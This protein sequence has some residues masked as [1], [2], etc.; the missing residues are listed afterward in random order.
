M[1]ISKSRES[2]PC[3]IS[4]GGAFWWLVL[5]ARTRPCTS[6]KFGCSC[7]K[8]AFGPMPSPPSGEQHSTGANHILNSIPRLDSEARKH[9]FTS[10]VPA[11]LATN[12][13]NVLDVQT[14]EL[15]QSAF[16]P[17]VPA[18]PPAELW[19]RIVGSDVEAY[20]IHG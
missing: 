3:I 9:V 7:S 17:A 18:H 13:I 12:T 11:L 20:Q 19:F 2:S 6:V 10:H 5:R 1:Q 16:T 14:K 4:F 15:R 8:E